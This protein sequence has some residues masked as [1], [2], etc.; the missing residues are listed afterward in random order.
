VPF[1]SNKSA[2]APDTCGQAID[3]PLNDVLAVY[4][5]RPADWI[6]TPGAKMSTHCPKL[7]QE[8]ATSSLAVAP[9][10]MAA[11]T[12]AGVKPQASAPELPAATTTVTP[13][14]TAALIACST[15]ASLPCPPRLALMTAGRWP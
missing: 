4:E 9:T 12:Y 14:C 13:A 5:L 10:V 15:E 7:L 11:G 1:F 2:A 8:G 6:P 3:V